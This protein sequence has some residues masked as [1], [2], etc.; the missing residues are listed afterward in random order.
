MPKNAVLSTISSLIFLSFQMISAT[1]RGS[2][3]YPYQALIDPGAILQGHKPAI[4][5]NATIFADSQKDDTVNRPLDGKVEFPM[6]QVGI[7]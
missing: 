1:Y 4:K 5:F 2:I 3:P 7:P 6:R